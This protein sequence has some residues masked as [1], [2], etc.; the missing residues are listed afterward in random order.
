M[1]KVPRS[2]DDVAECVEATLARVGPRIVIAMPLGIGKPNPLANEFYRRARRDPA[3]KLKICTALSLRTPQW[4]GELERRYWEP[5]IERVFGDAMPLDYARDIRAGEVPENIEISEFF[6]PSG[7]LLNA[8]HSQRH[9][10]STNYTHVARDLVA[11][12]VNV[13]AQLVA[14]RGSGASSEYSM[15]SNPDIVVDLL[16]MLAPSRAQGREVVVIGEVNR[17][18]PFMLGPA[19]IGAETFDYLVEHPRYEYDLF[20]PPNPALGTVDYA[21]GLYAANLVRD[22]GTLQ[23]GIGELADAIIYGLQLRHRQ[24]DEF[25]EILRVL[26]VPQRFANISAGIGGDAPF[27]IGLYGCTEMFAA[28][29]LELYRS[30]VLRRRVYPDVRIQTLLNEARIGETVDERLLAA[31]PGCGFDTPLTSA[32]FDVLRSIGVFREECRYSRGVIKLADGAGRPGGGAAR[33]G[34]GGSGVEARLDDGAVRCK[35]LASYTGRQL[36]GGILL[37]GSFF[38]GPRGFYAALRNLPE[39]ERRQFSMGGVSFTNQLEGHDPALKIAQRQHGRFFNTTMMVTLL[40]AAVSDGLADGRVVS[41]VGGQYNFVAM[42]HSLPGARSILAVRSTREHDGI[43]RSNILWSYAHVTIPRH[44]RDIV[45][46]EYG[47][48]DLRGRSDQDV[49]AALLNIADSRFQHALVREAQAAG[50]LASDYRIPDEHR[51]NTPQS[52]EQRFALSRARGLFSE[53]PF[54]TDLTREEI[55]LAKALG[56]MKRNRFALWPGLRSLISSTLDSSIPPA[57]AAYLERMQLAAP[58][59]PEE[60]R[61]QRLLVRELK[62]VLRA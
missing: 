32:D 10:T 22:G 43:V 28:G 53:F 31:L 33:P 23:V 24:C 18:M 61:W 35:L 14:K 12:G 3:I 13:I 9:H 15:G 44:L 30:G 25:R 8:A 45:I 49:I 29:F 46:T 20:A 27:E 54:G 40:G 34:G 6:L 19:A 59:S 39:S 2:F 41:G 26:Q 55:V 1:L 5:L 16:E 48:A 4:H 36:E 56:K 51:N 11:Q 60:R 47:I 21:I 57:L 38:L 62:A 7:A 50:K 52:L 17:Q 37:H 42:A 58:A